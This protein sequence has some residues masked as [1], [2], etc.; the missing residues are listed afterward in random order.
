[1]NKRIDRERARR[2]AVRRNDRLRAAT[3]T[4]RRTAGQPEVV[5]DPRARGKGWI[6]GITA[7]AAVLVGVVVVLTN[8]G[9]SNDGS[10]LKT[11]MN[12]TLVDGATGALPISDVPTAYDVTYRLETLDDPGPNANDAAAGDTAAAPGDPPTSSTSAI[13]TVPGTVESQA[14][15]SVTT[16]TERFLVRRPF[17]SSLSNRAGAPP[18]EATNWTILS[19]LGVTTSGTSSDGEGP[20]VEAIMPSAGVGDWRLDATLADFVT[21]QT[22]VLGARRTLLGRE[23]QVYRTGAPLEAYDVTPPTATTYADVC[24]DSSGLL[25]EQVVVNDGKLLEHLTAVDV[26]PAATPADAEFSITGAP[27]GVADG[28]MDLTPIGAAQLTDQSYW[29]FGAVPVG[30]QLRGHYTLSQNAT[31]A[32]SVS[33]TGDTTGA[34]PSTVVLSY[35]DV[36]TDGPNLL[37]VH[38]GPT[39]VEPGATLDGTGSTS[40]SGAGTITSSATSPVLGAI[41]L[42][43]KLTGNTVLA[44]P[45]QTPDWFVQVTG[46]MPRAVLQTAAD[47]LTHTA[48]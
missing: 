35:V 27:A 15:G 32:G 10:S 39:S 38:Q 21:D 20:T 34:A 12:A 16:S 46:T 25:L 28:G 36:Y 4:R 24:I 40:G 14:S 2:A 5:A 37:I 26:D 29:G 1:V 17:Q 11:A 43:S 8:S 13:P 6:I 3:S 45:P 41:I 44:H 7:S 22:F 19:G 23:C 42:E 9:S 30:Y 47:A 18:G 48:A 33:S 31:D